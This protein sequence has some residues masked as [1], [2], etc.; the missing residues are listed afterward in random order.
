MKI[1]V[2]GSGVSGLTAALLLSRRH[3]VVLLEREERLG[4]HARTVDVAG[5][6]GEPV[7]VDTGFIVHN[8]R[9][10]PLLRR[11]FDELG[12]L[13]RPSD[14]SMS[15]RCDGCGLEYAGGR[16][17]AGLL[18]T[19]RNAT[20]ARHLDML[21]QIRRFHRHGRAVLADPA[22]RGLT[23]GQLLHEGGYSRHFRQH[24]VLPLVG[25]V[26]SC[27]HEMAEAY[28]AHSLLRFLDNHGLLAVGGAP[29]WRTV[30]GGSRRYVERAAH[31]IGHVRTSAEVVGVLRDSRG[32]TV[33]VAPDE[34]LRVDALVVATHADQALKLLD[35]ATEDERVVLGAWR[36]N[37]SEAALHTDTSVLPTRSRARASWNSLLDGCGAGASAD[38][39][40]VRVTYDLSR[41]MGLATDGGLRHCVSLNQSDRLA[42]DAILDRT[43]FEH[44][45]Y[46]HE[47][48]EAQRRL[49]ELDGIRR[50]WFCGAYHG[51]GFHEDG[52]ASGVR[53]AGQLGVTW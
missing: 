14:M 53:V 5:P 51:W 20:S 36:Y 12:V 4:G 47:S 24:V 42:P 10:Y 31:R 29:T 16:G 43:V 22:R 19:W 40:P 23:L 8:D 33:H 46:T 1:A 27:S 38:D 30:L 15:V 28:P 26:W 13:T 21:G 7:A 49:P 17:V 2:V 34:E 39:A 11:L 3:S 37:R 48:L 44:P 50:T 41:L 52:C 18:P 35:D 45:V 6:N 9:T 32:V 25:A